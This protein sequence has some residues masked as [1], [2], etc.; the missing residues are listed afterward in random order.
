MKEL[1][2]NNYCIHFNQSA[3]S[4]HNSPL[5]L[6]ELSALNGSYSLFI[7]VPAELCFFPSLLSLNCSSRPTSQ[8]FCGLPV[9]EL[10]VEYLSVDILIKRDLFYLSLF[11]LF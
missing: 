5:V 11:V 7:S 10:K 3:L 2:N 1:L 6:W 4:S 9:K 8:Q